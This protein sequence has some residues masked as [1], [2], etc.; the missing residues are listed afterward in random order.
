VNTITAKAAAA[1][2]TSTKGRIFSVTFIK[3]TTG[4]TRTM[5]A[6]T[7]VTAH[8]KGG[9]AA[10]SFSA[11]ALLSVYDLQAKGYRSIPLDAIVSLKEGGELYT[12]ER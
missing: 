2:L 9:D 3:R 5:V 6:R 1:L 7:G 12:V 4:E 10:Y 8:L 11:N